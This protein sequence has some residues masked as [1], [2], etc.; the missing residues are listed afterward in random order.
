MLSNLK[1]ITKPTQLRKLTYMSLT[2]Q[3]TDRL[4]CYGNHLTLHYTDLVAIIKSYDHL[5]A[6]TR[7]KFCIVLSQ[8]A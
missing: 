8:H 3:A 6:T 1:S 2:S 5:E 4:G 7:A